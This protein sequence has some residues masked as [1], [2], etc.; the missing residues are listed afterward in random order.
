MSTR[1]VPQ[2]Y[3]DCLRLIQHV[4][5]GSSKKGIAVRT[6][7]RNQFRKNTDPDKIE[8]YKADAIRALSNYLLAM[9]ISKDDKAKTAVDEFHHRSI[10]KKS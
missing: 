3:R 10:P 6:I 8:L 9:N 7:V 5:P 4:A 2:L 1:T